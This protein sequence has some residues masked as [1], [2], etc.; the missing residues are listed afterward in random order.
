MEF[1]L[2]YDRDKDSLRILEIVRSDGT[3]AKPQFVMEN[4]IAQV[5]DKFASINTHIETK[6]LPAR[7]YPPGT[8]WPCGYCRWGVVCWTGYEKEFEVMAKE[9]EIDQELEDVIAY[10]LQAS[11]DAKEMDKEAERLKEIVRTYMREKEYQSGRVGPYVVTR[12]LRH[13]TS[14]DEDLIP[15]DVAALAKQKNPFEVLTIRKPKAKEEK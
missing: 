8:D 3:R 11:G 6:S 13:S 5:Y 1:I 9:Q 7:P 4:V 15:P 14:W 2:D 12:S 10:Y